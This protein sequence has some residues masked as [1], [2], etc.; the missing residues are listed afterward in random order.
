MSKRAL[1]GIEKGKE[2]GGRGLSL[3]EAI[4]LSKLLGASLSTMLT[5][6]GE[7]LVWLTDDAA[8]DG[9][10]L[11]NW[12]RHGAVF[13]PASTREKLRDEIEQVVLAYAQA[14][15]DAKKGDDQAG[16]LDAARGLARS[17]VTYRKE[18]DERGVADAS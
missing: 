11:R 8:V 14:L 17:A 13:G 18:L 9:D 6:A 1:L 3:D 16:L 12:F 15:L 5:P 4:G 2:E 10:G 7:G